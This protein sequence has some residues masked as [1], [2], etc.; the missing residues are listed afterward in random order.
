MQWV[1]LDNNAT[2][3]PADEVVRAMAA[4]HEQYWANPS[5]VHRLG[6][7]ARQQ[8]ETA[9]EQVARL[10][11]AQ[12]RELIFT[13]GGTEANNLALWGLLSGGARRGGEGGVLVTS[14]VEH[15]AIREPAETLAEAGVA[16]R[17]LALG[18]HGVIEPATLGEALEEVVFGGEGGNGGGA[19]GGGDPAQRSPTRSE[20]AL[21]PGVVLVS[22]QWA[23]N[24]TGVVQPVAA[25]AE[26]VRAARAA[27]SA[28]GVRTRIYFHVDATQAV[29]KLPVDVGA[30]GT[31]LL[32]LSAHKFHGPKGIGALWVRRGVRL[33]PQQRGGPQERDRR[34]GTENTAGIIGMGAAAELAAAFVAD[35][36]RVAE[37]AAMR[38][39][40]ERAIV[41]AV[42]GTAGAEGV[43]V[44]VHGAGV[45]GVAGTAGVQRLWNTTNI[46]FVG[47]EAEA[48]LLGLSE[49]GVCVSA[50]A[51]CSS[52]S[53]EPSPVLLAM[54]VPEPVAHGSVRFSLSRETRQAELD[55]AAKRVGEVVG[56]LRQTL[57]LAAGA[58]QR[59]I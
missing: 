38:D 51:A 39:R 9:R 4:A 47:L 19:D 2:T 53:L 34:G 27:A 1:Y 56:R 3:R 33:R 59:K 25:L 12:P 26:R 7:M 6:Q 40:F 16:V 32:T 44:V 17:W 49:L 13:S 37:L 14:R 30:C 24:E 5:S 41:A 8:V 52:G 50:G 23:N 48:I 20:P 54:G 22:L 58:E 46:G 55:E 18:Q 10:I 57:P 35:G 29:G 45:A 43:S 11:G 21:T 31:D 36:A 28:R 15:S 42:G